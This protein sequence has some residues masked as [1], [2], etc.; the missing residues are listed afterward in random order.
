MSYVLFY[1]VLTNEL[2]K[3][4]SLSISYRIYGAPFPTL[5]V[6]KV[7]AYSLLWAQ[8]RTRASIFLG[9]NETEDALDRHKNS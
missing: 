3:V 6:T 2:D 1:K 8:S 5:E 4:A 7:S 9:I